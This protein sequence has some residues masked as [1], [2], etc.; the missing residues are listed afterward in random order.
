MTYP[1]IV[2]KPNKLIT[3]LLQ[4]TKLVNDLRNELSVCN[5]LQA[6]LQALKHRNHLVKLLIVHLLRITSSHA[7]LLAHSTASSQRRAT[8]IILRL[9]LVAHPTRRARVAHLARAAAL[10][11]VGGGIDGLVHALD[12]VGH[13][14]LAGERSLVALAREHWAAVLLGGVQA[15]R[16][17]FVAGEDGLGGKGLVV[18]L[19]VAAD[20][21]L[22]VGFEVFAINL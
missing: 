21:G 3:E 22:E 18:A 19:G 15:V 5:H 1:S 8:T 12:V 9:E 17:L 13:V 20:V 7:S 6:T 11:E 14:V 2:F 4:P 10:L 16:F